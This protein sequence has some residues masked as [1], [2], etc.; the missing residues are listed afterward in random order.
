V[1]V[2]VLLV[3]YRAYEDLARALDSLRPHLRPQDEVA[4]VDYE[5]ESARRGELTG[6][7]PWATFLARPDNLGFAAG[8]NLAAAATRAPFLLLLNPDTVIEGPV[9][10]QLEAWLLA[11][12]RVGVVGPR[13]LNADR[14]VQPSARRF[15]DLTT[16][17]GGRS[18]WL[19][20]RLPDN[21]F[22]RRNLIGREAI[23]PVQVD[24]V[25]GA[26]LLTRR[27]LF[28]RLRGLD[29]AFFMY[30]EDADYCRRVADA[31]FFCSYLPSATVLH[32]GGV[33]AQRDLPHAIRAFHRSAFRLYWKHASPLG[34]LPAPL[35]RAGL[36]ARG[37]LRVRQE[38]RRQRRRTG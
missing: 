29:E 23:A 5:S 36:W 34:R 16:L 31:E 28:E 17:L 8:V 13:V 19:T 1:A 38:R 30:W 6:R 9:P 26:C 15:P 33:S 25:A 37:E 10:Q 27:D 24:W 12:E 21:W 20:R 4:V 2:A 35:V 11:H 22:S 18:T 14:S 7:Y 32:V 3:N